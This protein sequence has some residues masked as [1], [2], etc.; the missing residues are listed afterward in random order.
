FH[1]GHCQLGGKESVYFLGSFWLVWVKDK[2]GLLGMFFV[3]KTTWKD[4]PGISS[5]F[6]CISFWGYSSHICA[7]FMG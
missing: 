4:W 7:G 3:I 2:G 5:L 1:R 6:S